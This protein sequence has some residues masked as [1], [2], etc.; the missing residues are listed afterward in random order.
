MLYL[1]GHLFVLEASLWVF[2]LTRG[3]PLSA[4]RLSAAFATSFSTSIAT[5]LAF[6]V[7]L[8]RLFYAEW[9]VALNIGLSGIVY[10]VLATFLAIPVAR[11]LRMVED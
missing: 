4:L 10:P 6:N 5:A 2:G 8:Y 7:V 3:R 1:T 9:Y 11:S